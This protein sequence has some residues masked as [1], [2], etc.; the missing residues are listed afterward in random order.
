MDANPDSFFTTSE[1][2]SCEQLAANQHIIPDRSGIYAWFFKEIPPGLMGIEKCYRR[3]G[4][5]LLYIGIVPKTPK[6]NR[7]LR[8]RIYGDHLKGNAYGSTLRRSLGCLLSQKLGILLRRA[9]TGKKMI[10]CAGESCTGE[11]L[12]TEWMMHN[13][14]VTWHV[15]DQPW[16]IE[17][18]MI[19][20][21][22]LPINIQH[23]SQNENYP[24]LK[25]IR[26]R[27][28]QTARTL[29]IVNCH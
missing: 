19:T 24:I 16:L 3:E 17:T 22:F 23:N 27:A 13:A 5:T 2:F 28:K 29:S 14:Y 4:F 25:E 6:G 10:L 11:G 12:L 7:H 26:R 18:G 1:L 9:G 20:D 15:H 21:N 8:N